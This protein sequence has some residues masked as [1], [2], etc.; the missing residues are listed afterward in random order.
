MTLT[1]QF[2]NLVDLATD[3]VYNYQICSNNKAL[4]ERE[5]EYVTAAENLQLSILNHLVTEYHLDEMEV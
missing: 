5:N 3:I 1:K 4:K 2:E